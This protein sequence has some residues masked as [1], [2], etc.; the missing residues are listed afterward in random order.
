MEEYRKTKKVKGIFG[1]ERETDLGE[2]PEG[3]HKAIADFLTTLGPTRVIG[4]Q[5]PGAWYRWIAP[6]TDVWYWQE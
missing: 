5:T 6:I 4:I 3:Y 1:K 2:D